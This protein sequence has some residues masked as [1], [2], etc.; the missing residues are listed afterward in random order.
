MLATIKLVTLGL[1]ENM[2]V[3]DLVANSA[4][5][6]KRLLILC[7]HGISMEDE[8]LWRPRL[9][10]APEVLERRLEMLKKGAYSVLPL[11][12][13][14]QRLRAGNLPGRS[15]AL[16]FDDGTYDFY[17]QVYPRLKSFGFPV[18]V[19]QTTYHTDYERPIF[20]LIC[21]YMLWK[22]RADVLPAA[23]EL[24]LTQP[25]DLRTELGRHRVVRTLIERSERE[26]KTGRQKDE[27]AG[28]LAELLGIDYEALAA[29]RILQLMNGR[30]LGEVAR[31]GVDIQLHS[32]RHQT[33][34]DEALFRREISDNRARIRAL[35]GIEAVHFCYPSGVYRP[36][37]LEW[38]R[39]ENVV[40]ATTC[41]AGLATVQS[42]PLLLPRFVDTAGR[43]ATE[44]ESW[45]AGVGDLLATR[46]NATQSYIL[47]RD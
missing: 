47:P 8:H 35:T 7:Y 43:S 5:R 33:P 13:A 29:K 2:R 18:T 12:E 3:F 11:A 40:S 24:G 19:Y 44:F 4:W 36:E 22:R 38:L 20:N 32:H 17:K 42:D 30:E 21:S 26:G 1:L 14:L 37:F 10:M 34:M 41:D 6:Q 46:R 23:P 16:T 25:L 15:V 39:K 31:A 45:L 27:L 9:Y 28:Q